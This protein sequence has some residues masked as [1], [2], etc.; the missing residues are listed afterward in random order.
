[1]SGVGA[2]CKLHELVLVAAVVT[3]RPGVSRRRRRRSVIEMELGSPA[4]ASPTLD[5]SNKAA[6]EEG[7]S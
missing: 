4:S 6:L 1:M 3:D 7:R 2:R 5:V